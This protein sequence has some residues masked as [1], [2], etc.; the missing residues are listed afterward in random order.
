MDRSDARTMTRNHRRGRAP[1][2]SA[3]LTTCSLLAIF[4]AGTGCNTKAVAI[5]QCRE[6]EHVRC[7]ASVGCGT[8]KSSEVEECKRIYNDQC[9]H[10]I[11]GPESPT[12][13][14]QDDCVSLIRD[15]GEQAA[16]SEKGKASYEKACDIVG[17]PWENSACEFLNPSAG[18]ASG[19]EE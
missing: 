16:L 12:S 1:R 4:F 2:T 5:D 3:L 6:I 10:G 11:A 13:K 7:E 14:Q 17:A 9:L 19:D 15:A 8:I 18:G